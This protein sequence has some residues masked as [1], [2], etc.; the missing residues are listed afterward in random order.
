M[1]PLI[2]LA[3]R[4]RRHSYSSIKKY[5]ECPAAYAY[6]YI[7]KL[8]DP[9]TVA[10][11]RGTRLHKL[12]EDYL[13]NTAEQV[14]FDIRKI[15]LEV[16]KLKQ[17]GAVAERVWL[18]DKNWE[19]TNDPDTAKIKAVID[20]HYLSNDLLKLHDYKSGREYPSHADQLEFY[21]IVGLCQFPGARR[22]ESSAIYIDTGAEGAVR[23]VIREMLPKLRTRWVD[24]IARMD[25]DVAFIP[26]GGGHCKRCP[27][28]SSAGGPC[29]AEVRG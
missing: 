3:K 8:P 10:M 16:Y 28:R 15:G 19:P 14:P 6:S 2:N 21:S 7:A 5:K 23:S 12:A 17:R 25:D 22:A 26:T 20:V 11:L 9:P 4:P 13:N 24:D 1:S 29:D 18:L 27:Y